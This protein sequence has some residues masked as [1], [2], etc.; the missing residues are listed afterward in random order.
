MSPEE[1]HQND[2]RHGTPLLRGKAETVT[3][4]QP[5][6][7]TGPRTTYSSL[8]VSEEGLQESW[9]GSFYKGL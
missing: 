5:G 2:Q 1:G 6:E 9:R 3:V 8:P 7:E 4:V